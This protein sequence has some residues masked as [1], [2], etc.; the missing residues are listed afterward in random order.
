MSVHQCPRCELRFR[1]KPEVIAHL[2]DDHGV[3]PESVELNRLI[4]H[5][6]VHPHRHV[7]NAAPSRR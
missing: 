2:V 5:S 6:D 7:P 4:A 1:G 3:E